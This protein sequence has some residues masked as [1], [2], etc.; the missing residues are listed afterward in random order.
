MDN[1]VIITVEGAKYFSGVPTRQ[2]LREFSD[3][4]RKTGDIPDDRD[5]ECVIFLPG[6]I[7]ITLGPRVYSA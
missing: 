2:V 5:V 6:G 1:A 3:H 7:R 4:L